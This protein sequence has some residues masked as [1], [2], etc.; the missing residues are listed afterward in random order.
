MHDLLFFCYYGRTLIMH[1]SFI[2][3]KRKEKGAT[4]QREFVYGH[5]IIWFFLS[6]LYST[7]LVIRDR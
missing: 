5:C 1:A 4:M 3:V 7:A 6:E 2:Y